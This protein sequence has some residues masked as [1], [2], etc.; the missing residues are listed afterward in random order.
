MQLCDKVQAVTAGIPGVAAATAIT[1]KVQPR[2]AVP[3]QFKRCAEYNV[4]IN[5]ALKEFYKD[6]PSIV[7]AVLAVGLLNFSLEVAEHQQSHYSLNSVIVASMCVS[8]DAR[9]FVEY[10][11]PT[12]NDSAAKLVRAV[13]EYVLG[14]MKKLVKDAVVGVVGESTHA[15]AV[16]ADENLPKFQWIGR[17]GGQFFHHSVQKAMIDHADIEIAIPTML[18]DMFNENDLFRMY[19]TFRAILDKKCGSGGDIPKAARMSESPAFLRG[20]AS[21]ALP[22]Q[23]QQQQHN[24]HSATA[25]PAVDVDSLLRDQPAQNHADY[26]MFPT[27]TYVP[28]SRTQSIDPITVDSRAVSTVGLSAAFDVSDHA[29]SAA[30]FN[31]F[32]VEPVRAPEASVHAPVATL[33]EE[34]IITEEEL[35]R[36]PEFEAVADTLVVGAASAMP[37]PPPQQRTRKRSA[38]VHDVDSEDSETSDESDNDDDDDEEYN[39]SDIMITP[40]QKRS[41]GGR[42]SSTAK[43]SGGRSGGSTGGNRKRG[44]RNRR[45]R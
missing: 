7:I 3:P 34:N 33:P 44:G 24:D 27:E 9:S 19:R 10:E 13:H 11:C 25:E 16:P 1:K 37:P 28:E 29:V 4:S 18:G 17:H 20:V 22:K 26:E 41:R 12:K 6:F 30:V 8:Y 35:E 43:S 5:E 23:Q 14:S 38:V 39:D 15:A 45:R 21:M 40:K 32:Y 2:I 31:P 36:D 42:G